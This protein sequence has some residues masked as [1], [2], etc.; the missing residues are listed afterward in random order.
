MLLEKN[1]IANKTHQRK[2]NFVRV[3]H[4]EKL[5]GI[6]NTEGKDR[7]SL[8]S[9]LFLIG[10]L[11]FLGDGILELTEGISIHAVLHN[12]ASLLFTIGSI[13]SLLDARAE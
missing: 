9:W 8:V 7:T 11:I 10:S 1:Q 4:P 2:K 3:I 6:K 12:V 13:F 5:S